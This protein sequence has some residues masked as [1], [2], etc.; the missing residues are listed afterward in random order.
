M[1]AKVVQHVSRIKLENFTGSQRL[2]DFQT[3][4]DLLT[5]TLFHSHT[6]SISHSFT[7]DM[8]NNFCFHVY[9]QMLKM[10]MLFVD[11][12]TLSCDWTDHR[13]G[14]QLKTGQDLAGPLPPRA[15]GE[16]SNFHHKTMLIKVKSRVP[17]KL[18]SP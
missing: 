4:F 15:C 7:L 12:S 9:P 6:L 2:S 18:L 8:L 16:C 13:A 1:K 17:I 5:L 14:S 11:S 10:T 3:F